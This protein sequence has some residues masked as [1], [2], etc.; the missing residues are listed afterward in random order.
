MGRYWPATLVRTHP[1]LLLPGMASD[2]EVVAAIGVGLTA[3]AP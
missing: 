3:A 1:D 2:F